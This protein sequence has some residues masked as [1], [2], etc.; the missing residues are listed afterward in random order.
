VEFRDGTL[1]NIDTH[2]LIRTRAT[3]R[4]TTLA[5]T[6][7]ISNMDDAFALKNPDDFQYGT[8][9]LII[10]DVTTT[11]A[12]LVNAAKPFADVNASVTLLALARA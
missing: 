4:Q 11:G 12:T 9:V 2:M 7:R 6:K 5:R 10:D 8:H 1:S 3:E